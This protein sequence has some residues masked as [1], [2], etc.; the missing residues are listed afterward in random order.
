MNKRLLKEVIWSMGDRQETLAEALN[1]SQSRLSAKMTGYRGAEFTQSEI[2]KIK[3]RYMLSNEEL[4]N[5]F[6]D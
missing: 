6:F 4:C 3:S 5:I 1:I 2:M